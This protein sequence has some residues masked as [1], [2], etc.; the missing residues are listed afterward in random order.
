MRSSHQ[1]FVDRNPALL[2]Q[3]SGVVLLF[4]GEGNLNRLIG[5]FG[6]INTI[7]PGYGA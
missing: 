4:V 3:G 5:G 1:S 2:D 6:Q 7:L